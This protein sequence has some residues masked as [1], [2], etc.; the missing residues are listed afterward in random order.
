MKRS[1]IGLTALLLAIGLLVVAY[2]VAAS[3][4]FLAIPLLGLSGVAMIVSRWQRRKW[5]KSEL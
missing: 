2:L 1:A 4:G 3:N 5:A